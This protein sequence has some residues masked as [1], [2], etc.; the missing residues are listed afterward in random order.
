MQR[1]A[2]CLLALMVAAASGCKPLASTTGLQ[3]P[4][5]RIYYP[6]LPD[7]PRYQFLASFSDTAAWAGKSET[8]FSQFI[9]GTSKQESPKTKIVNPYGIAVGDGKLYICDIGV[10]AVHVVDFAGNRSYLLGSPKT[11]VRPGSIT[12]APDGTRYVCDIGLR[13]VAV[14]DSQD[15]F[16]KYLGDPE[17]CAPADVAVY[18]DELYVVDAM[19]GRIEVWS[20]AGELKRTIAQ[21]GRGPDQFQRP[22]SVAIDP[23]GLIYVTDVIGSAI[24][25]FDQGG[26]M[27]RELATAGDTPG[28]LARPKGLRIDAANGLVY[29]ADPHFDTVQVFNFEGQVMLFIR[30]QNNLPQGMISPTWIAMDTSCLPYFKKYI[31][32]DFQVEY[33]LFVSNEFGKNKIG[34]YAFGK[35]P[36]RRPTTQPGSTRP[37]ALGPA[38]RP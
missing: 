24:K 37:A 6:R 20:K 36:A 5:E 33:L 3:L 2:L 11:L 31:A 15:R 27:V 17:R 12:I 4:S 22:G 1:I 29:V 30:E 18:R 32:S 14:F 9:A 13:K 8:S 16:V 23:D 34:V 35:G 26:K 25:V 7:Q 28:S 38:V 10:N 19:G 21:A